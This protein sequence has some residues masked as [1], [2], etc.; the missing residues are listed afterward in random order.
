ME[1][2]RLGRCQQ[3]SEVQQAAGMQVPV[4][5]AERKTAVRMTAEVLHKRSVRCSDL[6]TFFQEAEACRLRF[7]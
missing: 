4:A 7:Q 3:H 1:G 2:H 6:Q 5:A